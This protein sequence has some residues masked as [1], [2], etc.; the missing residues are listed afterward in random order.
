MTGVQ[1][2]ALP[3]S[4]ADVQRELIRSHV[5]GN[6]TTVDD[7]RYTAHDRQHLG[8]AVHGGAHEASLADATEE[9][10]WEV[11]LPSTAG[12]PDLLGV[13]AE[14]IGETDERAGHA[15]VV[16]EAA[17]S[18]V[19]EISTH[20]N[21]PLYGFYRLKLFDQWTGDLPHDATSPDVEAALEALPGI[22]DV[23]VQR[24][25]LPDA[26]FDRLVTD[27]G[28][29]SSAASWAVAARYATTT[30]GARRW[31]VTFH[32]IVGDVPLLQT[33]CDA[34]QTGATLFARAGRDAVVRAREVRRGTGSILTG[35]IRLVLDGNATSWV[36]VGQD[37]SEFAANLEG[38]LWNLTNASR[39]TSYGSASV[40]P[41]SNATNKMRRVA[42]SFH[43]W[44]SDPWRRPD[45]LT[46]E[47]RLGG[48]A[49]TASLIGWPLPGFATERGAKWNA[50]GGFFRLKVRLHEPL[51]GDSSP[52]N[53]VIL[54]N[55]SRF[56]RALPAHASPSEVEEALNETLGD[57][58]INVSVWEP[59]NA[60]LVRHY[61]QDN[62]TIYRVA[63]LGAGP[64][65]LIQAD[66]SDCWTYG[67]DNLLQR[68]DAIERAIWRGGRD[69][70]A[71]RLAGLRATAGAATRPELREGRS[72]CRVL[73]GE[74][75]E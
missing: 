67:D 18:E 53:D 65:P 28:D 64:L 6:A 73:G 56:T 5:V 16:R 46:V 10:A 9:R 22:G 42:V 38:A 25:L 58:N 52:A 23:S 45:A 19:Q 43:R 40:R 29:L 15:E 63:L 69:A 17:L 61:Y 36:D 41:M 62:R 60:T 33:C 54:E 24:E 31:R 1:T 2:C 3:I 71:A 35:R 7:A 47:R 8:V 70:S 11:T 74:R 13:N 37:A 30:L 59:D 72:S 75:R 27:Y 44:R 26:H 21:S 39:A 34:S 66:D 55:A 20:A 4:A 32:D 14:A 51:L 68:Y 49:A 50:T 12:A 57:V 48:T